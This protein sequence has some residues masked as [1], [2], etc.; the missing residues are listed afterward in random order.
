LPGTPTATG[1]LNA[2]NNFAFDEASLFYAGRIY[3]NLGAFVQLT[4]DGVADTLFLDNTDIRIADQK[5][6]L[7]QNFVYG[8]SFN[9]SPTTQDV[10]NTTPVWGFPYASSPIAATPAAGPVIGAFGGQ[11]GG[12]TAYTLINDL[13]YLE[14]GAYTSFSKGAQ[15]SMGNW[16]GLKIQ[17]GAPY[18]RVALQKDWNGH[19]FSLGHF[20]FSANVVPDLTM[21]SAHD[22]Y[23][24]L[25]IDVNYQY[26]ANPKHIYEFK[27]SYI[28]EQQT[29]SATYAGGTGADKRKQNLNFLGLSASYT[30]DQTY[31]FSLGYNH[32]F[33]TT[34]MTLNSYSTTGR[35]NSEYFTAEIDY[36]PFGKD[37]TLLSSLT[38]LRLALQYTGYTQFNGAVHDDGTGRAR[39]AGNNN[40][41][42][43]NGWVS[44]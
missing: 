19:Y 36:I 14:A 16:G 1:K 42:F 44:F 2:N 15:N 28:N 31:S 8:V 3:K 4:Y 11:V 21:P 12:A 34:D 43:L 25:G 38:N 20:G 32:N 26:L 41:L 24:D 40:T 9:N 6:W 33:G 10:W 27:G 29:L 7:G 17:G 18:W 39:T 13:V 35:P 37:A 5:D 30:Y 23:T 22:S